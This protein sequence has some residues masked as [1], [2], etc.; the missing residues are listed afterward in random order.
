MFSGT[1]NRTDKWHSV[2]SASQILPSSMSRDTKTRT[3]ITDELSDWLLV[4]LAS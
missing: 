1:H 3:D 4:T 2:V